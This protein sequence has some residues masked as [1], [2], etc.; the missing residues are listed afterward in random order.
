MLTSAQTASS[1]SS[2]MASRI[3]DQIMVETNLFEIT[4]KEAPRMLWEGD[5]PRISPVFE[6]SPT[7]ND[8]DAS[9]HSLKVSGIDLL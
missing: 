7:G 4:V 2:C 3:P 6:S 9:K 5:Q 1:S 8:P